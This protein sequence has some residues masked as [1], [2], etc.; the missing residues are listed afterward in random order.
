MP[1][2]QDP[3]ADAAEAQQALRDR[4]LARAGGHRAR[5]ELV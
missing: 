5:V 1:T 2:F 3:A 4:R